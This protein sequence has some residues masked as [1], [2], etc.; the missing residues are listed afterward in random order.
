MRGTYAIPGASRSHTRRIAAGETE[1]NSYRGARRQRELDYR[2]IKEIWAV[3]ENRIAVRF[4]YE[5]QDASGN[6]FRSKD[7]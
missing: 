2:L 6:W 1:R 5:W 7:G 4:A 3:R